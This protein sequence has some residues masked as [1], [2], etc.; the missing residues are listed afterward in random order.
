MALEILEVFFPSPH[1]NWYPNF[2]VLKRSKE[3][4]WVSTYYECESYLTG[5]G[6]FTHLTCP[7]E[8]SLERVRTQKDVEL[9]KPKGIRDP[10]NYQSLVTWE[11]LVL[12]QRFR[13]ER[14]LREVYRRSLY[15]F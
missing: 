3:S 12:W 5:N 15:K 7:I 8:V 4:V 10:D 2:F 14:D 1:S 9:P 6:V 11:K 13:L